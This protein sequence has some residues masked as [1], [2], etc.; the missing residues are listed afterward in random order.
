MMKHFDRSIA[1]ALIGIASLL[2][3][4]GHGSGEETDSSVD[5]YMERLFSEE[6]AV[7]SIVHCPAPARLA[8]LDLVLK[9]ALANDEHS[10]KAI[11]YL[12]RIALI[13]RLRH[14][15]GD[16][17][18]DEFRDRLLRV[19][20]KRWDR[21]DCYWSDDLLWTLS[22]ALDI[23]PE[24]QQINLNYYNGGCHATHSLRRVARRV[25]G[26]KMSASLRRGRIEIP[27]DLLMQRLSFFDDF[28]DMP[29]EKQLK[30]VKMFI[31]YWNTTTVPQATT[32]G[33]RI[34][35][36]SGDERPSH[37]LRKL[38]SRIQH[39]PEE[40]QALLLERA[41][42][43]MKGPRPAGFSMQPGSRVNQLLSRLEMSWRIVWAI[44]NSDHVWELLHAPHTDKHEGLG[45]EMLR[46]VRH[47]GCNP[48]RI[49]LIAERMPENPEHFTKDWVYHPPSNR[50]HPLPHQSAAH[51][52][53]HT[54]FSKQ[55]PFPARVKVWVTEGPDGGT[56]VEKERIR[57]QELQVWLAENRELLEARQYWL[58]RIPSNMAPRKPAV[59]RV[60]R[61]KGEAEGGGIPE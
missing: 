11:E 55:A 44:G 25:Y 53:Y 60:F 12:G 10:E 36:F 6:I 21:I 22:Y 9:R 54:I 37:L 48:A 49:L 35:S 41:V 58:T 13:P 2:G 8:I 20:C 33:D 38:T 16:D 3:F 61:Q 19:P 24:W 45:W 5:Q 42:E 31:P 46:A 43:W 56:G 50:R 39:L 18:C 32:L 59:W 29:D 57:Y 40:V 4:P 26:P 23:V 15:L 52:I 14:K 7:E 51:L 17:I 1:V 34:V 28:L 30:I 47:Q 27:Q